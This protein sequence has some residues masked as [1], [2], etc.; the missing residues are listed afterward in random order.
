DLLGFKNNIPN[1]LLQ[2]KVLTD[3]LK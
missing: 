3:A 2:G 1:G